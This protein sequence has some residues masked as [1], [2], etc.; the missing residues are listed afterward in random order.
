M[1]GTLSFNLPEEN[2]EFQVAQLGHKYKSALAF[3]DTWLRNEI[4]YGNRPDAKTL[5]E[6]RDKLYAC[7]KEEEISLW[8]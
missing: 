7:V 6:I 3:F 1:K 5:Q 4:K 8:D 2:E